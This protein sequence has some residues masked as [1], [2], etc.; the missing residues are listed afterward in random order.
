LTDAAEPVIGYIGAGAV[1]EKRLF[2]ANTELPDIRYETGY[3]GCGTIDTVLIKDAPTIF[4]SMTILPLY[5]IYIP[6]TSILI[7]YAAATAECT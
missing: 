7:G 5:N 6:Q 2:I 3:A 1:T 4:G